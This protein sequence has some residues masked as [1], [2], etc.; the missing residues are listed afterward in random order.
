MHTSIAALLWG[1]M[2]LLDHVTN[3][4]QRLDVQ[5]LFIAAQGAADERVPRSG[6]AHTCDADGKHHSVRLVHGLITLSVPRHHCVNS[7][8]RRVKPQV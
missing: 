8:R 2:S 6:K 3:I 7:A 1:H 4:G 5:A